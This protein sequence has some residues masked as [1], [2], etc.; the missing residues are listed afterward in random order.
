M[1]KYLA[2]LISYKTLSWLPAR[3]AY[4]IADGIGGIMYAVRP[5]LRRNVQRNMR[6]VMGPEATEREVR[7]ASRR[8]MRNATRYYADLVRIPRLDVNRFYQERINMVSGLQQL[9]EAVASKKG[10]I[11]VS[12]HYGN[13]EVVLQAAVAIGIQA[14]TLTEPLKPERLND[15]VQ[16][17]RASQGQVYRPLSLSAVR[18]AVR[19]LRRGE[20]VPLLCDRDIQNTGMM[21]PFFGAETRIPTGAAE[22]ALRTG[23]VVIPMFCRRTKGGRF[24]VFSEPSLDMT[25]TGN[26]EEDIRV[27]TLRIV[28]A[29]EKFVLAD[30]GQWIVLESVWEPEE[31]T[32]KPSL[33]RQSANRR[34]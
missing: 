15:L 18:E 10:V 23:A 17:L 33:V 25:V 31:R 9:H 2:L 13:P 19:R 24:D 3:A 4:F 8:V 16:R 20:V 29:I 22:L 27:N 21:L 34:V 1:F 30:P 5:G 26:H 11:I 32:E 28:A 14:F 7:A 6:Q 12:A